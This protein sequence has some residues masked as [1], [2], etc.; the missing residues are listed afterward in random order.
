MCSLLLVLLTC[1]DH[2][3]LCIDYLCLTDRDSS[4]ATCSTV[5]GQY[6]RGR[7]VLVEVDKHFRPGVANLSDLNAEETIERETVLLQIVEHILLNSSISRVKKNLV[8]L[9]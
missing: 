6:R 4:P 2:F 7:F 5:L 9:L 3:L 1:L 8:E